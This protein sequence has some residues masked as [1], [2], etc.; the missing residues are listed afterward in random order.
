MIPKASPS[1]PRRHFGTFGAFALLFVVVLYSASAQSIGE[2]LAA[3]TQGGLDIHHINTGEGNAAFLVLPDATTLLIDCG[4]GQAG[5][6]PKY[7][8]PRRPDDSRLPGEWVAR[9]VKRVHPGGAEA[10]V[11]YAVISHFHGDHMG[12]VAEFL[13]HVRVRTFLDR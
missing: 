5:R 8:A 4:Y 1:K 6:A 2:T 10:P 9:Y 12:G 11:D 3:F 13:Q 7:K